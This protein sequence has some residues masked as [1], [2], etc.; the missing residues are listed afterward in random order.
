ME[1][2]ELAVDECR[3][4][5]MAHVR[6]LVDYWSDEDRRKGDCHSRLSGLAHSILV[7][8]DGGSELP[9]FELLTMPHDDDKEF[10]R[11][12][13]DNWWPKSVDI[14]GGLHEI[15]YSDEWPRK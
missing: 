13:G 11:Q 9:A 7:A 14:A 3:D 12:N 2:H 5:F 4:E 10:N 1:P 6:A 8:I 15:L